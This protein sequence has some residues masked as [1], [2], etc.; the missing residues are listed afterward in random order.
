MGRV[1]VKTRTIKTILLTI[2][3]L[4]QTTT[5]C[6]VAR[7]APALRVAVMSSWPKRLA[8]S[9]RNSLGG[10]K[11]SI[12]KELVNSRNLA[13]VGVVST[14]TLLLA[15]S[16][17]AW[18]EGKEE[19]FDESHEKQ[20]I[21]WD[22]LIKQ[23][24]EELKKGNYSDDEI[25]RDGKQYTVG[26]WY[27]KC[28]DERDKAFLS[29]LAQ[30]RIEG[31]WAHWQDD[32]RPYLLR[33]AVGAI[34]VSI[35]RENRSRENYRLILLNQA[36]SPFFIPRVLDSFLALYP[37]ERYLLDELNKK[38]WQK[39]IFTPALDTNTIKDFIKDFV[40]SCVTEKIIDEGVYRAGL[41]AR[42]DAQE[43]V[44]R[45][46]IRCAYNHISNIINAWQ[47]DG[48]VVYHYAPK[49]PESIA[50]ILAEDALIDEARER[51]NPAA[52]MQG[53]LRSYN[54]DERAKIIERLKRET[55]KSAKAQ[56]NLP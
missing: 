25:M 26:D 24:T 7:V 6:F 52:W 46:A 54:R 20:N 9:S 44:T 11:S 21:D 22:A 48:V 13:K 33:F 34:A 17:K 32:L 29:G 36:I 19:E 3:V 27:V 41:T 49:D 40:E 47:S 1:I 18:S 12:K 50:R 42:S 10:I 37:Q 14:G 23:A 28:M 45:G 43:I 30:D 55:W 4:I 15:A 2:C 35:E 16:K 39:G 51:V 5:N 53:G 38:P 8:C 56:D 31:V